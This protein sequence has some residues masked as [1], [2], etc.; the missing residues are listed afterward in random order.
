MSSLTIAFSF[1][2]MRKTAFYD[3]TTVR[4]E[5]ADAEMR[6]RTLWT[7]ADYVNTMGLT[8]DAGRF[9]S[10]EH[11]SDSS[12]AVVLN[13]TAVKQLG[14]TAEQA[15]GKRV[16]LAQFDTVYKEVVGVVKDY[17]FTS[18]KQKIEPLIISYV[19]DRG[20]LLVRVSGKDLASAVAS[21][22]KIWSDYNTGFPLDFQ[23]LDE[24]IDR[25][26]TTERV[27][28]KIFTLFSIVSVFIAC[29]GVL[30]LGTYLASQRKKEI[31]VRKVLGATTQQVSTLL[32][33]DLLILVV[34]ANI[35]AIPFGYWAVNK[36]LEGFA[37]RIAL[38]PF[39][40]VIATGSV[41]LIASLIAGLN[42]SRIAMQNPVKSLRT[43]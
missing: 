37:Y 8:V 9:F 12:Q 11:P 19:N 20:N 30:G 13:E 29:L 15:I 14:W 23:F 36:W 40:F 31:G 22:E 2:G 28:G 26:Y 39:V 32:M 25:L 4:V 27:Q 34:V 24:V 7:D 16:M 38:E 10:E 41:L 6:M 33:K 43:E 1:D 35:L 18:L 5:G 21:L 42:A 17:H 3:A